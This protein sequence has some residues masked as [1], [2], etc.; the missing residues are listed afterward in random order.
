MELAK[1]IHEEFQKPF[2]QS[3]VLEHLFTFRSIVQREKTRSEEIIK[4]EQDVGSVLRN[5]S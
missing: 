3:K 4:L 5:L 1:Q 2:K